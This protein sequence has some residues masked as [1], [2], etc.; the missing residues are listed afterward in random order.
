MAGGGGATPAAAAA[1]GQQPSGVPAPFH[2]GAATGDGLPTTAATRRE[3]T[4][5]FHGLNE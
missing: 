2:R 5:I 3:A 4:K 1:L